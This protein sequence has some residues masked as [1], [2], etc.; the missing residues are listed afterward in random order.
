VDGGWVA[1]LVAPESAETVPA[2][3]G[4]LLATQ[5]WVWKRTGSDE[6]AVSSN[7]PKIF[8][9]APSRSLG[10]ISEN[11]V[12]LVTEKGECVILDLLCG[13]SVV[14]VPVPLNHG[15]YVSVF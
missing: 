2:R 3:S 12:V 15:W 6:L 1:V 7:D 13:T 4:A 8:D 10:A 9:I 14:H 5:L 11:L